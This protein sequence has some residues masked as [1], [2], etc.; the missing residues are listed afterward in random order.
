MYQRCTKIDGIIAC[1][2]YSFIGFLPQVS[3]SFS[4]LL[5]VEYWS[6]QDNSFV[7]TEASRSWLQVSHCCGW[8]SDIEPTVVPPSML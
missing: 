7:H 3:A 4:A 8:C 6:E 2:C 5:Y 1:P